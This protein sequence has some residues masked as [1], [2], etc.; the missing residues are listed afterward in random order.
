MAGASNHPALSSSTS[1]G[2]GN[3]SSEHL[4]DGQG[5]ECPYHSHIFQEPLSYRARE[6]LANTMD[7]F[8]I[9]HP[10]EQYTIFTRPDNIKTSINRECVCPVMRGDNLG[11]TETE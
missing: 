9:H 2:A 7:R 10:G 1:Q 11:S 5:T 8:M 3:G 6:T 4:I